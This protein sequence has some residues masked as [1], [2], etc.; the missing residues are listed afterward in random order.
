MYILMKIPVLDTTAK[1]V[2]GETSSSGLCRA[3]VGLWCGELAALGRYDGAEGGVMCW[4]FLGRW[5]RISRD[6]E[7]LRQSEKGPEKERDCV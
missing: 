4:S 3:Y 1:R 5:S 2:D 7:G 6:S